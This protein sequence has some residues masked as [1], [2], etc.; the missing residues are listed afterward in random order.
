MGKLDQFAS[1]I[2][3]PV[4]MWAT[5]LR[6]PFWGLQNDLSMLAKNRAPLINKEEEIGKD[7]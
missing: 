3:E 4:L 5:A 2:H 1:R 7:K 6:R